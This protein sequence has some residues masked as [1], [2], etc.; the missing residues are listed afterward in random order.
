MEYLDHTWRLPKTNMYQKK[1]RA[2]GGTSETAAHSFASTPQATG[3]DEEG[4]KAGNS[5]AS[6][7]EGIGIDEDSYMPDYL[8]KER[9]EGRFQQRFELCVNRQREAL[10]LQRANK[11][12]SRAFSLTNT[13]FARRMILSDTHELLVTLST[14]EPCSPLRAEGLKS[15]TLEMDG[16]W[17]RGVFQRLRVIC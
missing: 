14:T 10:C 8:S 4:Y 3:T 11:H 5:F 6:L 17:R 7:P 16:L 12:Q 13:T 15:Q 2:N 9:A 1:H